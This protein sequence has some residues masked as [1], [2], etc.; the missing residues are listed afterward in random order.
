MDR[1]IVAIVGRPNVGKSTLFNRIVGQR[2]AIVEDVPGITRD[3][4]Y[5]EA[6]WR[7]RQFVV[8]DTGGILFNET[9][10]LKV[11]TAQQAQLAID[12][13]DVI[14]FVV[15]ATEGITGTDEELAEELRKTQ[16]VPVLV[17][18]NK[19]DNEKL[20]LEAAQFYQ[21]GLGEVYPVSSVHGR[22][23]A[24][25]LDAVVDTMPPTTGQ[26]ALP[27]DAIRLSIVGRPNVG[28]SSMVNA[29]LGEERVIVSNIPGTTR[30]A[31]DT[32]FKHNEHELV[33]IDTAGIRRAGKIQGSVEYYTVLRAIR[34]LERSDVALLIIDAADGITDGDKRVGGYIYQAGRGCV[35]VVNKWD[36][37]KGKISYREFTA[38][39][40]K[41]I[42]FLNFAPVVF[43]SALE[44][45]G[46]KDAVE[47]AIE[48]S[49]N[50]ALRIPTG[51]L[52]RIIQDALDAHPLAVKGR[53][54]KIRYA[55][56]PSV[57]PP[58]II[59]FVNDPDLVHFS[60]IRYL[61]NQIRKVYGYE[62]TPIRILPRKGEK[63]KD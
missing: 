5:S 7:G 52:N 60:Y 22:G 8:T 55:T 28:K 11:Q 20:E 25:L 6:E 19:V 21:M 30:D 59:L 1:A 50:H 56:M 3:R 37:V 12:E 16:Q 32:L 51:E 29:I 53:E 44:G 39:I 27:S 31:I 46:V 48:V 13:A 61:E 36:M 34:A 2:I 47:T 42:A 33:L 14:L 9:D 57:K 24:D 49:A 17:V 18:A 43:T 35:I 26:E 63:G 40:R 10:P 45:F 15:D 4:L 41:E 38:Q 54:L 58:T 23:L 62:G